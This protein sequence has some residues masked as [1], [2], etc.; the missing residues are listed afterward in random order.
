[1]DSPAQLTCAYVCG[2][3][4]HH[5]L[6]GLLLAALGAALMFHDRRD[7]PWGLRRFP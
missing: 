2:R 3:R 7:A 5:G 6:V 4:L 1:M